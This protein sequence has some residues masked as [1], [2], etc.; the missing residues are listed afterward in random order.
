MATLL[1]DEVESNFDVFEKQWPNDLHK[2]QGALSGSRKKFVD[3]YLRISTIQ[4][5]RTSVIL[6]NVSEGAEAFFFEAQNDFLISHCLARC[7]SSRQ[8]LK[9]LRGAIENIYFSLYYN[10]HPVELAKWEEGRYRINF[11][12][13]NSYFES[14]P[15][16]HN[17]PQGLQS[18]A[19][20]KDEYSTLSKAV[21]GSAKA[22]RM[23]KNLTEI[24]LWGS[25]AAAVGKWATRESHVITSINILL[26]HLFADKL[27]G[28]S[29]RNLREIIGLVASKPQ[30]KIMKDTLK[31][32]FPTN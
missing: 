27:Q 13:L 21:H 25:D 3:S 8:A 14:H 32:T 9:A 12:E 10:D 19:T 18:L 7:G 30:Q 1:R 31:I 29:N 20:L 16:V 2:A 23:T 22:F 4:A 28:A 24:H 15:A 6:G 5:W 26:C 17:R 11:P